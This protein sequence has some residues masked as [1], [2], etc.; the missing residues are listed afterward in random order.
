MSFRSFVARLRGT[1]EPLTLHGIPV[2]VENTRE[3]IDSA[4]VLERLDAALAVIERT[5]PW[6]LAHLRRDL[7]RIHVVR[8]P[9]RGA[10]DPATRSC[11]TELTFLAN[12]AFSDAQRAASIVHEGMHARVF[13]VTGG[14]PMTE[15]PREERLCRRAELEFG[16]ALPPEEG[17][18][19]VERA[20]Q[21]LALADAEV[22]P[23]V[24]WREAW[25]R[26]AA[27]DAEREHRAR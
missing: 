11:I 14:L 17:Q 25:A 20:R 16:E 7:A 27:V 2:L 26:T 1:P 19:V 10:F 15:R 23:E 8:F 21:S 22:A 3:D 4:L 9:C 24:D 12:P 13:A 18:P 6:R 5:Q